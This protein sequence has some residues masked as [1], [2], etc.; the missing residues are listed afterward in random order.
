LTSQVCDVV[1][2]VSPDIVVNCVGI[3]KQREDANDLAK[4]IGI[5][6][7]LPA[8]L[9]FACERAGA[10]LIQISTDCTFDGKKG[11][12]I[13]S[14][15][16]SATD[17]YGT[18]KYMGEVAGAVVIR[19]SIVGRTNRDRYGLFEWFIGNRGKE[20]NGYVNAIYSGLTTNEL[21]RVVSMIIK[22]PIPAGIYHV[23]SKP[24][25]KYDML[26]S[27]NEKMALGI[28]VNRYEDFVEDRS[29][30]SSFFKG[31]TGYSPPSWEDMLGEIANLER[32]YENV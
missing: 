30:D 13:E 5:N 9:S 19:T 27:L 20:V 6:S 1:R 25:S 10:R 12:Y 4:S 29:L 18:T 24:I 8:Y 14:D 2:S 16:K 11:M 21:S 23:S 22:N 26:C 17:I 15:E 3:I 28:K 31:T 32:E 7:M